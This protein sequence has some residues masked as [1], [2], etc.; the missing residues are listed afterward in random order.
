MQ[1]HQVRTRSESGQVFK[2]KH[3]NVPSYP[4]VQDVEKLGIGEPGFPC[5]KSEQIQY[6]RESK[7]V[8]F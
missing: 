5:P 1:D 7:E 4:E 8:F 3:M 6:E 2:L